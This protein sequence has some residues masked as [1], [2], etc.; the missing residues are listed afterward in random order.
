[1]LY[2]FYLAEADSSH[3]RA[4]RGFA[5]EASLT[6]AFLITGSY[7]LFLN[8]THVVRSALAVARVVL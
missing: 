7:G 1:L 3:T 4:V 8:A 5:F 2:I 6:R